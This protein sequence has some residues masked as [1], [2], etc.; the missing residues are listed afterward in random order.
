MVLHLPQHM[1]PP[2]L[3]SG[4]VGQRRLAYTDEEGA[5]NE[6]EVVAAEHHC[7]RG[8]GRVGHRSVAAARTR[9][10]R[11]ATRC[12]SSKGAQIRP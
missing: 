9:A 10:T 3:S 11:S 12:R 7:I 6:A 1:P 8:E 5:H 4:V 2:D